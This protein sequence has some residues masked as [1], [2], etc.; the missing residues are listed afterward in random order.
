M[1]KTKF[2]I[3]GFYHL[4][5]RGVDRRK[6]FLDDKN[7]IRFLTDLAEFNNESGDS[8][9]KCEK[10]RKTDKTETKF[11]L[12]GKFSFLEMPKFVDIICYTLVPNHYHLLVKQLMERGVERFMHKLNLGYTKYFNLLNDR[13][14][15][16]FQGTFQ[17]VEVESDEQLLYLSSYINGNIEIHKIAKAADWQWS[18]YRDYLD[19]QKGTLRDKHPILS[20]FKDVVEYKKY[21]DVVI[22]EAAKRK[23]ENK[24]H[25]E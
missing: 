18:S 7:F 9:R 5:T 2:Q 4:F 12:E 16:L 20:Q 21:T 17:S 15:S 1:R 22:R 24:C 8:Q 13:S 11:R 25:L 3:D 6:V 10:R 23:Q 19:K 14:G